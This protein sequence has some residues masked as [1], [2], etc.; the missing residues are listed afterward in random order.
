[1]SP[2]SSI[3]VRVRPVPVVAWAAVWCAAAAVVGGLWS[4][5]AQPAAT[6]VP[7]GVSSADR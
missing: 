3:Q 1:M 5:T 7:A 4:A 6:D 2:R